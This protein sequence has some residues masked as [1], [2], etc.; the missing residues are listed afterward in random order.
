MLGTATVKA[1][2]VVKT[3]EISRDVLLRVIEDVPA[4]GQGLRQHM[5]TAGYVFE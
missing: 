4:L 2:T 5:K 1:K 3:L